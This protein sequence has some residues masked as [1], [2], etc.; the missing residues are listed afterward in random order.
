MAEPLLDDDSP[1]A[2]AVGL[3]F[4]AWQA[5]RLSWGFRF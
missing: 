3:S 5:G 4:P 1:T 2:F